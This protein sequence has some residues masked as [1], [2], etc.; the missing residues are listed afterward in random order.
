MWVCKLLQRYSPY[1]VV[2]CWRNQARCSLNIDC[3][4]AILLPTRSFHCSSCCW[5]QE[6][7]CGWTEDTIGRRT[8][9]KRGREKEWLPTKALTLGFKL[10][11]C[12]QGRISSTSPYKQGTEWLTIALRFTILSLWRERAGHLSSIATVSPP[13]LQHFFRNFG[14]LTR[15]WSYQSIVKE[16]YKIILAQYMNSRARLWYCASVMS[17]NISLSAGRWIVSYRLDDR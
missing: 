11:L 3:S 7:P 14:F 5:I 2:L 4:G 12:R 17:D 6:R 15:F 16:W 10:R 1:V 13:P 8:K 9:Q